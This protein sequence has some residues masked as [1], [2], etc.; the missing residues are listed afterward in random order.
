MTVA[1]AFPDIPF[2][3]SYNMSLEYASQF[4]REGWARN[5][6]PVAI[7]Q[8][9]FAEGVGYLGAW[10]V[11]DLN[12]QIGRKWRFEESRFYAGVAGDFAGSGK[13]G[14]LSYDLSWSY[15]Y[16]PGRT[17]MN[18]AEIC[19]GLALH[20]CFHG[21]NWRLGFNVNF[22]HDYELEESTIAPAATYTL[23]F[24]KER[25]IDL[26]IRAELYWGDTEK[27][28]N[29]TDGQ[30]DSNAFYAAVLRATLN[31]EFADGWTLSPSIAASTAPDRR[32]RHA[33]ANDEL[34]SAGT[35]WG[36]IRLTRSF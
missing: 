24:N 7:G 14:P 32:A 31:W 9:E 8:F 16:Y 35:I 19:F 25:T 28:R 11:Y 15:L 36:T 6:R 3:P 33:K 21:E 20:R 34:N 4:V 12:N 26:E 10:G 27:A 30:C 23:S 18:S 22:I 2:D 5:N 17:D 13:Y 29:M 1:E